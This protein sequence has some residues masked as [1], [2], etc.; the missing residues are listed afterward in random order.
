MSFNKKGQGGIPTWVFVV[1]I[2]AI[3]VWQVPS[4]RIWEK[5]V[6]PTTP[7]GPT[8]PGSSGLCPAGVMV[9]D[10]TLTVG[11]VQEMY[12]PTVNAETT[13]NLWHRVFQNNVDIGLKQD[14][15]SFTVDV[16]DK[17]AVYYAE[18]ASTAGAAY[19]AAKQEFVVPCDGGEV[20]TSQ[21]PDSNAFKLYSGNNISVKVFNEDN[22]N[23]NDASDNETLAAGDVITLDVNIDGSFEDA[24]SPYGKIIYVVDVNGSKY[25]DIDVVMGDGKSAV[26][27]TVPKSYSS[28][29]S[30]SDTYAFELP[31]CVTSCNIDYKLVV[32]VDDTLDPGTVDD[33]T[34]TY[35]D[36]DW[37]LNSDSGLM[38]FGANNDQDADVGYVNKAVT[39]QID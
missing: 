37:Y 8:T 6:T 14:E 7:V 16:G 33:I 11:K 12:N 18:N 31:G 10:V 19:Y 20:T 28:L 4:L 3:L 34:T 36:Q 23:L 39:I 15:T 30:D 25:D 32:D 35:F 2:V 29:G 24:F 21:M 22:G 17:M 27:A 38:E 26:K 1:A 13:E 9:E 5:A